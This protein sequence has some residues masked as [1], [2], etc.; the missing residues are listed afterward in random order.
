MV[1]RRRLQKHHAVGRIVA[2]GDRLGAERDEVGV[3]RGSDGRGER[4]GR[5]GGV[6]REKPDHGLDELIAELAAGSR[7]ELRPIGRELVLE[8]VE[9]V[10]E[11]ATWNMDYNSLLN[12]PKINGVTLKGNR[13]IESLGVTVLKNSDLDELLK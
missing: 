11:T 9:V 8:D 4:L 13:S 7:A 6:V 1:V 5:L 12:K 10:E 2:G 3:R